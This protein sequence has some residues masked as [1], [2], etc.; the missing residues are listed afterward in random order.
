MRN[1]HDEGRVYT[2]DR[3]MISTRSSLA[4]KQS[5]FPCYPITPA[6]LKYGAMELPQRRNAP[7]L[8]VR[9]VW[10]SLGSSSV[11]FKTLISLASSRVSDAPY[12]SVHLS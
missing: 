7:L 3:N 8:P 1:I 2:Y 4:P 6:N 10:S 11:V 5:L 9:G 12:Q